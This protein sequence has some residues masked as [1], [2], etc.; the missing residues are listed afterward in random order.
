MDWK[1]E[2]PAA[3]SSTLGIERQKQIDDEVCSLLY[4]FGPDRHI[5][6][7]EEITAYVCGMISAE[8]EACAKVADAVAEQAHIGYDP[9]MRDG[10]ETGAEDIASAIRARDGSSA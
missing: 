3:I 7:H 8:R 9:A 2:L 10:I 4:R 1:N 5:D 6:G